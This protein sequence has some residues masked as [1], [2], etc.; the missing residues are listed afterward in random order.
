MHN[1]LQREWD[2]L[3][4]RQGHHHALEPRGADPFSGKRPDGRSDSIMGGSRSLWWDLRVSIRTTGDPK[5]ALAE[6]SFPGLAIDHGEDEKI[7]KHAAAIT[8][9]RPGDLFVP[10]I[11]DE[12]GA[13]GPEG[14]AL[15]RRICAR[16]DNPAQAYTY[17]M[18]RLAIVAARRV[19]AIMHTKL[20]RVPLA[21]GP[22]AP[23]DPYGPHHGDDSPRPGDDPDSPANP[24]PALAAREADLTR[25]PSGRGDGSEAAPLTFDDTMDTEEADADDVT[26]T[27][28][29]A[30]GDTDETTMDSDDTDAA[31]RPADSAEESASGAAAATAAAPAPANPVATA[32]ATASPATPVAPAA[33]DAPVAPADA[34]APVATAL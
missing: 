22:L 16:A 28:S 20:L 27:R 3:Y 21:P 9:H 4:H 18:R 19:H 33:P 24:H 26:T 10:V 11:H 1:I 14:R 7:R 32:A 17:G 15:A 6:A 34:A 25:A 2:G 13:V 12:H 8:R 31:A 5:A 23:D 29:A 30:D